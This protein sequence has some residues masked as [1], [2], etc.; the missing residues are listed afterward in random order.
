MNRLSPITLLVL[1]VFTAAAMT[2]SALAAEAP[3]AAALDPVAQDAAAR[4][5]KPVVASRE[6]GREA[7]NAF[8]DFLRAYERGDIAMLQRHLDPSMIG[9]GQFLDG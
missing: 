5:A 7:Q 4:P 8:N 9:Y 1:A 6:R 2:S 3:A